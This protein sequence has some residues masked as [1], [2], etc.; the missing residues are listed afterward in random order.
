MYLSAGASAI[1]SLSISRDGKCFLANSADRVIRAYS[2]ERLA[3]GDRVQP[4]ELPG[5]LTPHVK[6]V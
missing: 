3:A 6:P 5:T 1:K 4:R 2:L